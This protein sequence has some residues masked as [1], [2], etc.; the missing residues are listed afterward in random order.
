MAAAVAG[1]DALREVL[2]AAG[3]G[4]GNTPPP[5]VCPGHTRPLAEVAFSPHTPDGYFLISGCLDG[6]PML[7]DASSGDWIGT[8]AGHKG[9]VW[10]AQLCSE[11]RLA[12]TG[13]GDFSAKV[14]DAV[15]GACLATLEHKHIVKSVDFR[16]DRACLATG[17]HEGLARVYDV[18]RGL[19]AHRLPRPLPR[20]GRRVP[21]PRRPRARARGRP[22]RRLAPGRFRR[23]EGRDHGRRHRLGPHGLL[24]RRRQRRDHARAQG[25]LRPRALPPL[26]PR[27]HKIRDGLR[28]R[29]DPP[30]GRRAAG[31]GLK[32]RRSHPKSSGCFA[33]KNA[34]RLPRGGPRTASAPPGARSRGLRGRRAAP[35]SRRAA[36]RET[37]Q[38]DRPGSSSARARR[39]ADDHRD[40]GRGAANR[41][42]ELEP[43]T[44]NKRATL[45]PTG[46]VR[47]TT[48]PSRRPAARR[49]RRLSPSPRRGPPASRGSAS[50]ARAARAPSTAPAASPR[51]PPPPPIPHDQN[52]QNSKRPPPS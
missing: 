14:W 30:L 13:S 43:R 42:P 44:E 27:R 5:I 40:T 38:D 31:R 9:A 25:P 36:R 10:S 26:P 48:G 24:R 35:G 2:S 20:G 18:E 46:R 52:A 4:A 45:G 23:R 28:G 8:F 29:H 33:K 22:P 11:A 1:A 50:A 39:E 47:T 15:T 12:A 51:E 37:N 21:A 34:E 19:G 7:R 32:S 6:S 17:G 49:A 16:G 41:R 3:G